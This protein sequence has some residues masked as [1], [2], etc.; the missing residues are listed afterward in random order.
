MVDTDTYPAPS[1]VVPPATPA[2]THILVVEDDEFLRDLLCR[3]LVQEGFLVSAAEDGE[4]AKTV[5]TREHPALILLDL[6]L[7]GIDGF[8]LLRFIRSQETVKDIPVIVLSNLGQ[9]EDAEKAM[10]LGANDY[11]VKAHFTPAEI[12]KKIRHLLRERYIP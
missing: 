11:L 9:R 6:I 10:R 2:R 8:T 12:L 1:S 5:L 7:P 4:K 3:K